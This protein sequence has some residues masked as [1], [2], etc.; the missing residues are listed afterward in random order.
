VVSVFVMNIISWN[1]RG[2]GG[3]KK[4]GSLSIAEGKTFVYSLYSRNKV[5]CG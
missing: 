3:L 4:K 2:L 5:V 1:V